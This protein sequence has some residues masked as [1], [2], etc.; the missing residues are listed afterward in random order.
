MMLEVRQAMANVLDHHS[1]ADMR[2]LSESN[3][4]SLMYHI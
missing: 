2:A 1:L 4:V 3:E